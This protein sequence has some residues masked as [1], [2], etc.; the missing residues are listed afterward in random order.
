MTAYRK[1]TQEQLL[2]EAAERFGPDAKGWKF[3]CPQCGD[4]ATPQDFIDAGADPG[5][6]GQDCIGRVTGALVKAGASN[7]RGCDWAAYGLLRG[8]WEIV[9]PVEGDKPERFM[10]AFALAGGDR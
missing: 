2:T 7:K 4:E 10:W 8:P 5:R 1:L 9:L 3:R 6:C